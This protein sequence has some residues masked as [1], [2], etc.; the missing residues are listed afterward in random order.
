[1]QP[2]MATSACNSADYPTTRELIGRSLLSSLV[3]NHHITQLTN[4][5]PHTG[6]RLRQNTNLRQSTKTQTGTKKTSRQKGKLQTHKGQRGTR[7]DMEKA[8]TNRQ[9]GTDKTHKDTMISTSGDSWLQE[10]TGGNKTMAGSRTHLVRGGVR[11]TWQSKTE[12]KAQVHVHVHE[13]TDMEK[14]DAD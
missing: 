11:G 6:S 2:N 7:T 5:S 14:W 4:L 8:T 12:P 1:M 9:I 13:K 3:L 10:S